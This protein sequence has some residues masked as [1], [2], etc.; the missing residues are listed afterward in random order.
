MQSKASVGRL[1]AVT[2]AIAAGVLGL[3]V[4]A[5]PFTRLIAPE[6][7]EVRVRTD[8]MVVRI[9]ELN[10]RIESLESLTTAM[11]SE[12][13]AFSKA[14]TKAG[15]NPDALK[16]AN[17]DVI[18]QKTSRDI[19]AIHSALG[20]DLER[21]LSVP[22]LRK[23]LEEIQKRLNERAATTARAIDRIYDQNKWFLGLI[24]MMAV[25]V[26]GLAVSSVFSSVLQ[27]RKEK[28]DR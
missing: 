11:A 12:L 5:F 22:L 8:A 27:S 3:L 20:S 14:I 13:S 15:E 25:A 9:E 24:A 19:E 4:A 23:D 26:V 1:T 10:R 18:L 28:A 21:T 17:T 16:A 6:D 7:Q 2:T